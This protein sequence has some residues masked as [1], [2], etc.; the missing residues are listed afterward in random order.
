MLRLTAASERRRKG[1]LMDTKLA[2]VPPK[3]VP[4]C[5]SCEGKGSVDV[6][7]QKLEWVDSLE[8]RTKTT[9]TQTTTVCNIGLQNRISGRTKPKIEAQRNGTTARVQTWL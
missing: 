4:G 6:R 2:L 7:A 9:M 8:N 1:I 3:T 5:G